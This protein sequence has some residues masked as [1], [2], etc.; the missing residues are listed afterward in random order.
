MLFFF[1]AAEAK[2]T[3][4][5]YVTPNVGLENIMK[6][7]RNKSRLSFPP[8]INFGTVLYLAGQSNTW[9]HN[10][11]AGTCCLP[12]T[13]PLINKSLPVWSNSLHV[14]AGLDW[15]LSFNGLFRTSKDIIPTPPQSKVF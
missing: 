6:I 8:F 12:Q 4:V 7:E 9:L 15:L 2:W 13:K 14:L 10:Y 3:K 11:H 1:S 5:V